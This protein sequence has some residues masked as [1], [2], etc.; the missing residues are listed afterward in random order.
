MAGL[1]GYTTKSGRRLSDILAAYVEKAEGPLGK[2]LYREGLG[3]L[4]QSRP[5]VPVDTGALRASGYVTQP[6]KEGN[7]IFVL[8]G[9]GGVAAKFNPK[10]G[11]S[12]GNY[13]LFVH[14][15]L[16]AF[17]HVGMAKFLE[18]PFNA[19]R[20][21]MSGRLADFVQG[22]LGPSGDIGPAGPEVDYDDVVI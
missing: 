22:K 12:T 15:N 16:D 7:V 21:G 2:G 14:E 8:I 11:E 18:I 17:H 20:A 10:T 3:I 4:A 1:G 19:A 5:L 9:Y 6:I 13:A